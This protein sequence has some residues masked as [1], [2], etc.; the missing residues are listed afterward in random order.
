MGSVNFW[1]I[2]ILFSEIPIMM[3][4]KWVVTFCIGIYILEVKIFSYKFWRKLFLICTFSYIILI[5]KCVLLNIQKLWEY[6]WLLY[7]KVYTICVPS[8]MIQWHC[9]VVTDGH[10]SATIN[11]NHTMNGDHSMTLYAAKNWNGLSFE[12]IL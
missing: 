10:Q 11:F 4:G 9:T 3:I 1:N 6:F 12:K 5:I 7:F 8:S 2:I